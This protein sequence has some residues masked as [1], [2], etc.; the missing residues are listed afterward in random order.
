MSES[1]DTMISHEDIIIETVSSIKVI[2]K[3]DIAPPITSSKQTEDITTNKG[4]MRRNTDI[5]GIKISCKKIKATSPSPLTTVESNESLEAQLES[6]RSEQMYTTGSNSTI[7]Q[8]SNRRSHRDR[9]TP[10]Q[11]LTTTKEGKRAL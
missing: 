7:I 9:N 2:E 3:G 8:V 1:L 10:N 5:S 11:L 4:L 6:L